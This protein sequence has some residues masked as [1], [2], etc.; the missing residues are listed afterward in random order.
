MKVPPTAFSHWKSEPL[1]FVKSCLVLNFF[2]L[3]GVIFGVTFGVIISCSKLG[4]T[5]GTLSS[6]SEETELTIDLFSS[7]YS[8]RLTL[9][10]VCS[11]P[12]V[13]AKDVLSPVAAPVGGLLPFAGAAAVVFFVVVY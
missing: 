3:L 5:S 9:A 4:L 12:R 11:L 13:P 8:F 10:A 2:R 6:L 7:A 1:C